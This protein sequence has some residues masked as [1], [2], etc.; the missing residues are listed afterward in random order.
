MLI[1]SRVLSPEEVG[2]WDAELLQISV[3][4][5]QKASL[6]LVKNCALMC[7]EA[8]IP[9]VVHP[10]GFSVLEERMFK[11][12]KVMA[13]WADLALILHDERSP[14]GG[15]LKGKYE[16]RFRKA[17]EELNSVTTV[18][19]ENATN[20]R[21]VQWFWSNYADSITLDIGHVEASGLDSVAFV[22]SL[23]ARIVGKIQYVH[24]HRNGSLRGGLTDHWY[25]TSGCREL[26]ALRELIKV[27]PNVSVILEINETEMIDD[28]LKLLNTL[29]DEF[30]I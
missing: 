27:K 26:R 25:L 30:R 24:M 29:R 3:Y 16:V 23:D 13:E 1:G 17:V 15:R 10:V 22:K 12:L 11:T 7:K 18:S 9:Y 2:L 14:D 21:D 4:S 28:S 6:N 5:W 20:T 8:G 19:F